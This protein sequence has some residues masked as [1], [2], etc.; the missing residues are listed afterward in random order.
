MGQIILVRS[1]VGMSTYTYEVEVSGR[2]LGLE[3]VKKLG[4]VTDQDLRHHERSD[5]VHDWYEI[6]PG[7]TISI[8]IDDGSEDI[9]IEVYEIPADPLPE[10]PQRLDDC[11]TGRISLEMCLSKYCRRIR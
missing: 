5:Y 4:L 9:G 6:N 8:E 1:Y 11:S 3:E 2:R 7:D 10:L